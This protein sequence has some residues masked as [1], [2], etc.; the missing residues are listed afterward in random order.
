MVNSRRSPLSGGNT[1]TWFRFVVAAAVVALLGWLFLSPSE[2][3]SWDDAAG[4]Q[5]LC[6]PL[7]M[8]VLWWDSPSS[9]S[10]DPSCVDSRTNRQ[11]TLMVVLAA[12]LALLVVS[13]PIAPGRSRR[14]GDPLFNFPHNADVPAEPGESPR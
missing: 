7:G 13:A 8:D 4:E 5:E 12:A 6:Q 14:P 9:Y 3:R 10:S 1:V 11:S 2:S